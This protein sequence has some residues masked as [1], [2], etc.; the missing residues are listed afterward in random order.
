LP[1]TFPS[2]SHAKGK[3][4]DVSITIDTLL[5]DSKDT[6]FGIEEEKISGL[7]RKNL[8]LFG[9]RKNLQFWGE[10]LGEVQTNCSSVCYAFFNTLVAEYKKL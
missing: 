6:S 2:T 9:S 3:E 8:P 4:I 5:E 1:H 10:Q 7:N